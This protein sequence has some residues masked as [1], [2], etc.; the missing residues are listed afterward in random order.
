[1]QEDDDAPADPSD[2]LALLRSLRASTVELALKL[3]DVL[4]DLE[5][6]AGYASVSFEIKRGKRG[7]IMITRSTRLA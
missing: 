3:N 7:P 4:A 5:D 6:N 2:L 1:M